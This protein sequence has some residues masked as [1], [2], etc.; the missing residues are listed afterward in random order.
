MSYQTADGKRVTLK[1]IEAAV[2][3]GRAEIGLFNG[4]LYIYNF[5]MYDRSLSCTSIKAARQAAKVEDRK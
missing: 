1:E 5:R 4:R 2:K 3:E